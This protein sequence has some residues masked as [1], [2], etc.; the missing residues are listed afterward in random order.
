MK[1]KIKFGVL[2][3]SVIAEKSMIP[4]IQKSSNAELH[5]LG[6]RS[7]KKL[8]RLSKKFSCKSSL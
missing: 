2:G 4:A 5:M 6:T 8:A 3:C 7:N 1:K